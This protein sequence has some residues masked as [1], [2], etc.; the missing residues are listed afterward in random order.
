ML[1]REA[2]NSGATIFFSSHIMS[3]VENLAKRVAIIRSGEIVEV[4]NTDNLIHSTVSRITIRFQ[5]THRLLPAGDTA[6]GVEV[7]LPGGSD[8]SIL[9]SDRGYGSPRE[10]AWRSARI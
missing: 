1:L 2:N 4:T 9:A 6:Q 10:C 3:E 8:Q 7:A 5:T